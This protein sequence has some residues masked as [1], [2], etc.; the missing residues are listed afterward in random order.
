MNVAKTIPDFRRLRGELAAPVGLV[1]TMGFLHDGHLSL[2]R[3][4]RA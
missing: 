1:P 4:A 2:V 3:R